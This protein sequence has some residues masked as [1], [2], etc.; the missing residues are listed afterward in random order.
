MLAILGVVADVL[1]HEFCMDVLL[2]AL[3]VSV[4]L[5]LYSVLTLAVPKEYD[6]DCALLKEI[7]P[8]E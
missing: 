3:F 1:T 8:D 7:G 6:G 2:P 4:R 5:I